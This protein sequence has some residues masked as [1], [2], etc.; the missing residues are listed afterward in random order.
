M[1]KKNIWRLLAFLKHDMNSAQFLKALKG[2]C[3]VA[4][5][6]TTGRSWYYQLR[7]KLKLRAIKQRSFGAW[8]IIL[9]L[10][11]IL[12]NACAPAT[13]LVLPTSVSL[14]ELATAATPSTPTVTILPPT[15]DLTATFVAKQTTPLP[16]NTRVTPVPTSVNTVVNII[17]P[18]AESNLLMGSLVE[19]FGLVQKEEADTVWVSL[20]TANGRLLVEQQATLNDIG[21][22]V[23]IPVPAFV[24]GA[25]TLQARVLDG[26]GVVQNMYQHPVMLVPNKETADRYLLLYRPE[27]DETAV[28]GFNVIFDG[29]MKFPVNNTVTVSI[30]ADECRTRVAS[31]NYVLGSSSKPFYWQ[32]FVIVPRDVT[33]A[34]CAVASFGEPG[35]ANWREAQMPINVLPTDHR[36]AKGIRI[37]QPTDG[38]ELIAGEKL[39]IYGTALNVADADVLVSIL[40]EN[41]RIVS[42]TPAVT[43]Y[44]GY[45]EV[46]LSLP[47]D[48]AGL[49]QIIVETGKDNDFAD[50]VNTVLIVP[51]PTPS[52]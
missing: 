32:G 26:A 29:E 48:V 49:A 45:W 51:P 33:G 2:R 17:T 22:D 23:L 30:W 3:S 31:Q 40:M 7:P 50:A 25:A 20:V 42:Q 18:D 12:I 21:W 36:D 46:S 5:S 11:V 38:S 43:D 16:T 35:E 28:S 27:L 4:P 47:F 19:L 15:L 9:F 39:L 1:R 14:S 34:V 52:P 13:D 44:W 37:G 41:G 24:S 6:F 10:L 8:N